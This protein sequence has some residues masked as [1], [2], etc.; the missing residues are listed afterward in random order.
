MNRPVLDLFVQIRAMKLPIPEA[1][2]R[3]HD[4][5][6]WRADMAW[7]AQRIILEVDGATWSGGR[8]V[9]GQGYERDAEKLNTAATLGYRVLR[10]TPKHIRS[11]QAI[12]WIKEMFATEADRAA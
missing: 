11:G 5:R 6:K 2:Y 8:H 3:F 7:P 10:V 12:A 4:Q 1:E 9:T